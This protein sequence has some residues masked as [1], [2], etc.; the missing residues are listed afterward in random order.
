MTLD[1]S[2]QHLPNHQDRKTMIP[3]LG[4]ELV[5]GS[6]PNGTLELR[7]P[8]SNSAKIPNDYNATCG[9]HS[10]SPIPAPA[11]DRHSAPA[12]TTKSFSHPSTPNESRSDSALSYSSEDRKLFVVIEE[13]TVLRDQNG[14]SKGCAFIKYSSQSEAIAAIEALHNSQTMQWAIAPLVVK[15]AD[16]D[17]ERQLRRQQ[18]QRQ[19]QQQQPPFNALTMGGAG[20]APVNLMNSLVQSNLTNGVTCLP[21]QATVGTVQQQAPP[22]QVAMPTCI[23]QAGQPSQ[24]N[25]AAVAAYQHALMA[26]AYPT[27]QF[28]TS[29]LTHPSFIPNTTVAVNS[30]TLPIQN[31]PASQLSQ[32]QPQTHQSQ[33]QS[34]YLNPMTAF[35]A[36]TAI[37]YTNPAQLTGVNHLQS[38]RPTAVSTSSSFTAASAPVNGYAQLT[39]TSSSNAAASSHTN[40]LISMGNF[41]MN[42][43]CATAAGMPPNSLAHIG[44]IV[45]LSDLALLSHSSFAALAQQANS[46]SQ[47]PVAIASECTPS[48]LIGLNG[49]ISDYANG[50]PNGLLISSAAGASASPSNFVTLGNGQCPQGS[51]ASTNG[52]LLAIP[53]VSLTAA[54][55]AAG[56]LAPTPGFITPSGSTPPTA[57]PTMLTAPGVAADPAALY[58]A[59][60][61]VALQSAS[62][63]AAP[64]QLSQL[65]P[66]FVT[67]HGTT[68]SHSTALN[69]AYLT[70]SALNATLAAAAASAQTLV[71][72]PLQ[73]LYTG[74]Q[75]YGLAYPAAAATYPSFHSLHHQVMSFPVHQKEG[76]RE[77][78]LTGPE[79]CNL[80]IYHLPQEFGDQEL[81]QMFM[82]FGTV[83]SAKVYVD[84]ATNQSKCFGF[85]SFDNQTS[86]QHAIQAMNGFQIG[87]K[88]LKVQL[89]RPKGGNIVTSKSGSP[90]QYDQLH[91]SS[92]PGSQEKF[93]TEQ[94]IVSPTENVAAAATAVP[95]V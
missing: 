72:D 41:G 67:A 82:P 56:L 85:V 52:T 57:S 91:G 1:N 19:Q 7:R 47:T 51:I 29:P 61:A 18:Q 11:A 2:N 20:I 3:D 73:Q 22:T 30:T 70:D 66:P 39:T 83:I 23:T 88:R 68:V 40:G 58:A 32:H 76:T 64:I 21:P 33:Q 75:A 63:A 60:A 8:S 71:S 6:H 62:P 25:S 42:S 44:S 79:G 93:Y 12:S 65:H 94:I 45:P 36:A 37:Q 92:L 14:M 4:L 87:L 34:A 59:A 35:M 86:A 50:Q 89:K 77:L 43:T 24:T 80:F 46:N 5:D 28:A 69:S 90:L 81:A 15:F 78:I 55:A 16:T 54:A 95:A 84:R 26:A 74:L 49:S 27:Q 53:N 38:S 9:F 48:G 10:F 17:R 31:S 13:C